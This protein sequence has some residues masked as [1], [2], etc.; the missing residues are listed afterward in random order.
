MDTELDVVGPRHDP[1]KDLNSVFN[2]TNR[3]I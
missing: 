3:D 1:F 2:E